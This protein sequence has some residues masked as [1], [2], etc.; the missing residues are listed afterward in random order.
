MDFLEFLSH[1]EWPL[2]ASAA[3]WL[4]RKPLQ[5]MLGEVTPTKVDAWGFKAEFEK[6]LAKVELLAPAVIGKLE[7]TQEAQ[8]LNAT[9]QVALP[10]PS[11][12][13]KSSAEP[14]TLASPDMIVLQAW[15][16]LES[17]MRKLSDA[18]GHSMPR[19]IEVA[20]RE[21][22]L[23]ADEVSALMELR[24]LRNNVAH[25]VDAPVTDAEATRFAAATE[26]LLKRITGAKY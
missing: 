6:S 25:S 22:G 10:P 20:A 9:G 2:V 16:Q 17:R 11:D 24:K 15:R 8:T 21:L 26:N 14:P 1:L 12:E 23:A 5:R 7:V 13:D 3:L 18:Q 19:R 4:L